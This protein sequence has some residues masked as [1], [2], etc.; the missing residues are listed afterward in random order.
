[1]KDRILMT[2][3]VLCSFTSCI[4]NRDTRFVVIYN[5]GKD[6]SEIVADKLEV[7]YDRAYFRTKKGYIKFH[8]VNGVY[9]PAG[10][11][12]KDNKFCK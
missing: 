6:T 8:N 12:F 1:M 3:I 7:I 4:K 11:D 10:C 5:N 2:M 9:E